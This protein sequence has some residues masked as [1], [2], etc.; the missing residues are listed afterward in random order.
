[1]AKDDDDVSS[2]EN[3]EVEEEE[4]DE[5][6]VNDLG[7]SDIVT[8]YQCAGK[9]VNDVLQL[10]ISKLQP[11]TKAIDLCELGDQMVIELSGKVYAQ[12]KGG[13]KMDRGLAFPTCISVNNCVGH[14][15][16]LQ[17]E[18]EVVIKQGDMVKIDV[19]VHIDGYIAVV[20]HTVVCGMNDEADPISGRQADAMQAAWVASECAHR[21]FKEGASNIEV[22]A[23]ITQVA[24]AFKCTA[25]E[26]VLSH[27]MKKHVVDANKVIINK[28]T[29][30]HQVKEEKMTANDVVG[31]D[32]V[33]STG[34]GKPK[35]LDART[36]VFKRDLE[37]KYSLKMK[38]SRAFFSEVNQRFP[39]LPF[40]LRA[41]DERSWRLGVT[42]CVKHGLFIE[43]PVL[44]EKPG[45]YVAQIKFTALLLPSGNVAR[46]TGNV[47]PPNVASKYSLEDEKLC[48]LL[49]QTTDNKKKK[50]QNKNKKKDT[51]GGD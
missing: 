37:E 14:Y 43:Y 39:T 15:S 8:K 3:D 24:Q 33:I 19:G 12:K 45:E 38:A 36:T 26:G 18:G 6:A 11:E 13:K 23:M 34:E 32:I 51:H 9:I 5:A 28:A 22:T 46:I 20:A 42:E 25:V 44:F 17:S 48:A 41:G 29:S 40:T 35:Q 30:E 7:N 27:Q 21:M 50:K 49:A 31:F 47:P 10:L 1:M 16:P 2:V 4:E